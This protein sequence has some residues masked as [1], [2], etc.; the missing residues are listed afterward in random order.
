M[1]FAPDSRRVAYGSRGIV[2][3]WR[4]GDSI[5]ARAKPAPTP[6]PVV[7]PVVAT[8]LPVPDAAQQ[9]EKTKAIH[10]TFKADYEKQT[11]DG[12]LALARKLLGVALET[13][14]K[15]VERFVLLREARELGTRA[16]DLQTSLKAIDEL[17]QRYTIEPLEMKVE[18]L[19]QLAAM[20]N[21]LGAARAVIEQYLLLV[22][23]LVA[24]DN[25]DPAL[26]LLGRGEALARKLINGLPLLNQ[27]EA[28]T[29]A[30]KEM[31]AGYET[32]KPHVA[33]L[34]EKPDDPDASLALGKYYCFTK[35]NWTRGLPLLRAGSDATV[36]ALAQKEL[37]GAV[38]PQ[39][40]AEIGDG[41]YDL[42]KADMGTGKLP[43]FRRAYHW[44]EQAVAGLS[45][46]TKTQTEQRI[47]ELDA[48]PG[49]KLPELVGLIRIF[50]G[51][52]DAV[53]GLAVS[54]DG[55][56]ALSGGAD[57]VL[58]VWDIR[59]GKELRRLEGSGGEIRSLGMSSDGQ[60][61]VSASSDGIVS[62]WEVETGRRLTTIS[63]GRTSPAE[64]VAISPD[65]QRV[66]YS[67]GK[68]VSVWEFD[69]QPKPLFSISGKL[70]SITSIAISP[71]GQLAL[72]GSQDGTVHV[73]ELVSRGT[74]SPARGK[75]FSAVL[76]V[77][78]SPNGRHALSGGSDRNVVLWD[79]L[80]G[81]L[82]YTFRGH[83]DRVTSV[84][85][86]PDG[87][88]IVTGSADKTVR[89]WDV[90]MQR[91]LTMF[92][93]HG[94]EVT[95]VAFTPDGHRVLSS[96]TDKTLRLWRLP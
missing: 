70:G 38:D 11:K 26:G 85:F 92:E 54:G 56:Q 79:I 43:C 9:E 23:Q 55:R 42:A 49:F 15:P 61:A 32:M 91:E 37:A 86:S 71:N 89:L 77:A 14:D 75:H 63:T 76:G 13:K 1:T 53:R 39:A 69:V 88:R 51:H 31:Q 12:Q 84:A 58:R 52:T 94:G 6:V 28:R 78:F 21:T 19:G 33:K 68:V 24:N 45:G 36:K 64:A 50:E 83:T 7:K 41:W 22:D 47:K 20:A 30:V 10:E 72:L 8:R 73:A 66:V 96:S 62:F 48:M 46:I 90:K 40:Q 2:S 60:K 34:K 59:T 18:T 57:R 25:Y 80:N 17:A 93:G 29:K 5:L 87:N 82:V 65:G 67:T 95:S 16:G 35:G 4:L 74:S 81:K 3:Q 27:V 44:Y